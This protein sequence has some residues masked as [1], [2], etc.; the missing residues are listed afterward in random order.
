MSVVLSVEDTGPCRK[1]VVVEIPAPAVD[2]EQ[3]RVMDEFGRQVELPGF[4]KGK[5]PRTVVAQRFKKEIE[6]EVVE[7]LLPRY[8]RQAEAESGLQPLLPPQVEEVTVEEGKPLTFRATIEVRPDFPLNSLDSITLPDPSIDPTEDE[9]QEAIDDL[10]RRHGDWAPVERAATQGDLVTVEIQQKSQD[11]ASEEE[12]PQTLSIEVGDPRVW[13]ELSMAVTGLEAEQKGQFT[14]AGGE[15]EAQEERS[16]GVKV[17]AVKEKDLPELDDDFAS[18]V[19]DFE[20]LEELREKISSQ[21]RKGKEGT[22]SQEREVSLLDQLREQHP[23]EL[24]ERVVEKEIQE[25]LT[26]QAEQL[27]MQGVDLDKAGIDW[28]AM[29]DQ[30]RPQAEKRV[31]GRLVLDAVVAEKEIEVTEQE[32]EAALAEIAQAQKT[33]TLAVR[34][35]LD[36]SGRLGQLKADLNRNKAVRQLLGET[37]DAA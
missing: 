4:R 29:M 25:L 27:A 5:V 2:A 6:G 3:R 17:V 1:L 10:R 37:E 7:R 32:F 23:L 13:E 36:Q 31:H 34:Q 26:R 35:G 16:Y 24:P 28:S 22:R 21:I 14:K 33:S 11:E 20:T 19:G 9:L 15:G 8:W 12:E 30:A 18:S